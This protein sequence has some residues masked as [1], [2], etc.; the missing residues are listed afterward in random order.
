MRALIEVEHREA[1]ITGASTS[2][3]NG[4][5]PMRKTRESATELE[6]RVDRLERMLNIIAAIYPDAVKKAD[7][8]LKNL[9][10]TMTAE[11]FGKMTFTQKLD[12]I[13]KEQERKQ[14]EEYKKLIESPNNNNEH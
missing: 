10:V 5:T 11:Q 2:K 14:R 3:V 6:K 7:E 12:M 13:A 9:G 4:N 8:M 1:F